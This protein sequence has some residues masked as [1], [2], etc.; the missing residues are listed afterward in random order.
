MLKQ[1]LQSFFQSARS[2]FSDK[3]SLAIFAG[4][5]ALFLGALYG[6]VAVKE[7]TVVQVI[8]TLLFIALAPVLF[9]MLQAAIITH[10]KS[11][12][13]NWPIVLRSS[14]KLAL[15]TLPVI[16]VGVGVALA[17]NKWQGHYTAPFFNAPLPG[18]APVPG[19]P[20][21][22]PVPPVYWPNVLFA[23]GRLLFFAV[24][25]PLTLIHF[26]IGAAGKEVRDFFQGGFRASATRLGQTLSQALSPGSLLIYVP[27][28]VLFALVPYA[29]LFARIPT[30]GAWSDIV[31]FS[32]RLLVVF[33]FVLVGWVITLRALAR[34]AGDAEKA[35]PAPVDEK[36]DPTPAT[37]VDQPE[38]T[39]V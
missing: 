36:P 4:L 24:V 20:A 1:P 26:W 28:L 3:S 7:A 27:G 13:I 19:I 33:L 23:W 10:A 29:V 39:T 31:V 30:K 38:M 32:A 22:R 15:V 5:Y 6:F 18:Q 21:P 17:M 2:L 34:N 37:A 12:S 9:F 35:L 14:T 25:V 8:L 16:L 11:G